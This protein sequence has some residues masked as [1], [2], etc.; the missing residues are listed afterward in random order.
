MNFGNKNNL[1]EVGLFA[2][3][4]NKIGLVVLETGSFFIFRWK[5]CFEREKER[6]RKKEIK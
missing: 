4:L 1:Y 5:S 3:S 6:E 2:L